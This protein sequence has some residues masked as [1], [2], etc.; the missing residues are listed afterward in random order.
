LELSACSAQQA[1]PVEELYVL[2]LC[3]AN[4]AECTEEVK[5]KICDQII[6]SI[7]DPGYSPINDAQGN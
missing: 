6:Q 2:A 7:E 5:F 4:D 3:D 1:A